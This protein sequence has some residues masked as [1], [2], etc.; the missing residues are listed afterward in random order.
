M[1]FDDGELWEDGVGD[2]GLC[3]SEK[4]MDIAAKNKTN[5]GLEPTPEGSFFGLGGGGGGSMM[6]DQE[7]VQKKK[8]ANNHGGLLDVVD[9]KA[10]QGGTIMS[11]TLPPTSSSSSMQMMDTG[12]SSSSNSQ[13]SKQSPSTKEEKGTSKGLFEKGWMTGSSPMKQED[14]EIK[15]SPFELVMSQVNTQKIAQICQEERSQ[16]DEEF[17]KK[18]QA[19]VNMLATMSQRFQV[20]AGQSRSL[21]ASVFGDTPLSAS[22]PPKKKSFSRGGGGRGGR[23]RASRGG[24]GGRGRGRG[25]GRGGGGGGDSKEQAAD[26][27]EQPMDDDSFL[28]LEA[29]ED[30]SLDDD[31]SSSSYQRG[32]Q[33]VNRNGFG[34]HIKNG[35]TAPF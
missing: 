25:R 27:P 29:E 19:R 8:L 18:G 31:S 21:L 23:G 5:F 14:G 7:G 33:N 28:S 3:S 32:R 9:G 13:S 26:L 6:M 17:E 15:K 20:R 12:N 16:L 4:R 1:N 34:M 10:T 2:G 11:D 35:A 24:G 30:N 22:E